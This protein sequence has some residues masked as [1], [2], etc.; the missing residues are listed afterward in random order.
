MSLAH[1]FGSEAEDDMA[2]LRVLSLGELADP[3][4]R[5]MMERTGDEMFGIYGHRPDVFKA[6]LKFYLP[7][8]YTGQLP[9][10]LKELVRLK[11]AEL[12]ECQR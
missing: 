6:F 12:N 1:T 7:A 2:R 9:F 8:K 4:L 11:I 3:E 10:A 5:A